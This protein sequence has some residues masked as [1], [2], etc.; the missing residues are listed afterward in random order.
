MVLPESPAPPTL[1]SPITA[2]W[3][4]NLRSN[5]QTFLISRSVALL[6]LDTGQAVATVPAGLPSVAYE[7]S[8]GG[9]EFWMTEYSVSQEIA[10]GLLKDEVA[11]A[12]AATSSVHRMPPQPIALTS[13]MVRASWAPYGSGRADADLGR[14]RSR[15]PPPL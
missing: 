4:A 12:V 7:T 14:W 2:E 11:A 9:R 5:P 1:A 15:S 13:A 8:V 10:R 6:D 3:Q